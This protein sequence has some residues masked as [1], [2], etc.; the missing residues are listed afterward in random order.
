MI[1]WTNSQS[2][3]NSRMNV[4]FGGNWLSGFWRIMN[5]YKWTAQR[6]GNIINLKTRWQ[7]SW[8]SNQNDFSYCWAT[9]HLDTSNE[10]CQFPF[11]FRRKSSKQIFKMATIVAIWDFLSQRFELFFYLQVTPVLPTQVSSQL[12][13][14]LRRRREKQI[15]SMA[16]IFDFQ[17][18]RF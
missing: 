15:F 18:E 3:F 12:A 5:L 9:S 11:R 6:Q 4:K 1:I 7:P 14:Q 13:F 16:A 8:T 10:L 17:S 2:H